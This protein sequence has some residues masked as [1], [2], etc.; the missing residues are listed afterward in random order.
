MK[1]ETIYFRNLLDGN[2]QWK[3][4]TFLGEKFDNMT[5]AIAFV[6]KNSAPYGTGLAP[7]SQVK[8][9]NASWDNL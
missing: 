1:R 3:P 4:L 6:R 7:L 9:N 8:M 5:E 2:S